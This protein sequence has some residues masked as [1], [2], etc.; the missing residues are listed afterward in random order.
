MNT[1]TTQTDTHDY[2]KKYNPHDF[3]KEIYE[4]WEKEGKFL[5]RES[6]TGEQFYIPMPPPNVTSMLHIG[7]SSMLSLQDIMTRYHRMKWDET[8]LLPGTDHAGI[9]TQVKVEE[10]LAKEWKNKHNMSREDFLSE[11]W[12]WNEKYGWIIQ[13]QFRKMWTSCDWTKEKFT[14]EDSMN[15]RVNKAFVDLY[16]KGLIYQGEYMVNYDPVLET[17]V[18]DQEVVH[19]EEQT[20]MYYITYFCSG[21]DNEI[22]IATTR[23]ETLLWDVAVAVNPKDR[24][25]KKLLKAG[26]TLILP[27]INREIPIIADD[28]VSMDFGTGAVKI[29]P[30]HDANDFAMAK[31]HDLPLNNIVMWKDGKML[32]VAGIFEWQDYKTARSNI[33][34]LLKSKWNLVKVEDHTAK[35]WYWERTGAKIETIISTQWFVKVDPLAQKVIKWYKN[36]DFK[37]IPERYNKVFE[38]WIF[39]LRDWCISRQLI[40]GHQIPVWYNEA[41]DVFCAETEE[42]AQ[43]QAWEWVELTRDPDA[44]D[45]WFSAWLWP[46]ATLDH[47]MWEWDQ[48]ELMKKFYPASV[49]ETGHDIIFFWVIR[50]MLFGY[51]FTG[52]TPFKTVYLH[53]LVKDAQ[54]RKMSKSLGNG[55]DPLDMIELHGTDAL[56]LTLSIGNTPGNDLKFDENNVINNK[57]FI[58]K[59]WNAARFVFSK[60][61]NPI[62]KNPDELEA[63][64]VKNYEELHTHEKWILSKLSYLSEKVTQWMEDYSFSE[65][66]QELQTFTKNEFCDYYIE[67]F[68]LSTET[69]TY[70]NEVIFYTLNK[71]L[72]LWHPYIPFVTSKIYSTL[73]FEGDL[74]EAKWWYVWMKRNPQV[75]KEKELMIAIIKEIRNLRSENSIAPNKKVWIKIYAKNK[76]AD[77][78]TKV[79][80]LIGGIVKAETIELIDKK[81]HDVNL[82]YGIIKSW[83]EVYVDTA[84]AIDIEK[85][86]ER[87]KEQIEDTKQYIAILDKKLLNGSFLERAP[88]HLIRKE[89]EKKSQ[90]MDKLEKLEAKLAKLAL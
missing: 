64:L 21:S 61:E 10:K 23:P 83:V 59:L 48:S 19:R 49:L 75:E 52:Q 18:S 5:P 90:A 79:L 11:C 44:L 25:Y 76:N 62:T 31:R 47:N 29:T 85:E 73:W 77:F 70:G 36:K 32:E 12:D 13:N 54:G 15:K 27:I 3:E 41:W 88:D 28:E 4:N 63:L 57:L 43:N 84:N 14:F 78:L 80:E 35:V 60:A 71:L 81:Q 2:P 69:S 55:I 38:D 53:W 20:K 30:A 87:M 37:I 22:V 46:F 74:I 51:E 26:R 82:V 58:N 6:T 24:R 9:S 89:M 39:N 67:E 72:T 34:E 16:N 17:V 86:S 8:L 7:H 1:N 66:G 40:W 45:T 65:A 50:M 68:K 42:E 33:V 56:R